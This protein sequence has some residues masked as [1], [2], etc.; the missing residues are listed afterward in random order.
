MRK[1]TVLIA[2]ALAAGGMTGASSAQAP[3]NDPK[4]QQQLAAACHDKFFKR[5][6]SCSMEE[7]R[8]LAAS[9]EFQMRFWKSPAA[10][11]PGGSASR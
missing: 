11:F 2:F 9:V 4:A 10:L 6:E 7:R 5:G 8:A 3:Q 1:S